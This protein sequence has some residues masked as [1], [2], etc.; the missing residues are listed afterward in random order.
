MNSN[1]QENS[2]VYWYQTMSTLLILY[3]QTMSTLL[4]LYWRSCYFDFS[5]V[6][7]IDQLL[8]W[9]N[10]IMKSK[11]G[12]YLGL[13]K[14]YKANPCSPISSLSFHLTTNGYFQDRILY[15]PRR[16]WR[17]SPFHHHYHSLFL[18]PYIPVVFSDMRYCNSWGRSPTRPVLPTITPEKPC[19]FLKDSS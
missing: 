16:H 9:F 10:F 2:S 5:S 14:W 12:H 3:W 15:L 11:R 1:P 18:R 17:I 6:I 8:Y 19:T 13:P 4:I 7:M